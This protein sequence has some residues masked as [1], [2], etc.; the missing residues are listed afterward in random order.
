MM[1][2]KVTRYIVVPV[3]SFSILCAAG[4]CVWIFSDEVQSDI[5][6]T[7]DVLLEEKVEFGKATFVDP[8]DLDYEEYR[9]V[10]N[11]GG[12][13]KIYDEASG[14]SLVPS[15]QFVFSNYHLTDRLEK[16]AEFEGYQFHYYFDFTHE[17]AIFQSTGYGEYIQTES[18]QSFATRKVLE[19]DWAAETTTVEFKPVFHY[20]KGKKP[21]SSAEYQQMLE[22]IYA[23]TTPSIFTLHVTFEKDG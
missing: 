3:M 6:L 9:I 2:G 7:G 22:A 15:L 18:A 20:K 23:D 14:I 11:Q 1:L 8:L 10:F 12:N 19:V 5:P 13:N 17:G 4:F 16:P 21:E